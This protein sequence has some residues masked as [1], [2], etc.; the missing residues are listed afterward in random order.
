M[1][2][3]VAVGLLADLL[4]TEAM[5]HNCYPGYR[6]ICVDTGADLGK[7]NSCLHRDDK[8]VP[9]NY[10]SAFASLQCNPAF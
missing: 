10:T 5:S 1:I 2:M 3:W 8:P 9:R 6:V 7:I 4:H